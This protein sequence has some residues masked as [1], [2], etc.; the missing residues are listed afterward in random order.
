MAREQAVTT[1]PSFGFDIGGPILTEDAL[2]VI[3]QCNW[4]FGK[5]PQTHVA[6]TTGVDG[7]ATGSVGTLKLTFPTSPASTKAVLNF[8][9]KINPD[10][11]GLTVGFRVDG[12]D[13]GFT[14]NVRVVIGG[15]TVDVALVFADNA[16]EK[17]GAF[18]T[19]TTGTGWQRVTVRLD[20][21]DVG[22]SPYLRNLRI[23]DD[24]ITSSLPSPT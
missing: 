4:S 5:R 24:E 15:Q 13:V 7:W 10:T 16:T 6:M 14:G 2:A 22:G 23:Q 17:T 1:R 11:V 9:I 21:T 19:A 8:M 20:T 3:K 18:V 12:M